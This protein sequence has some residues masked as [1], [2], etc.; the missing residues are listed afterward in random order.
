MDGVSCAVRTTAAAVSARAR[1]AV[2]EFRGMGNGRA[3]RISRRCLLDAALRHYLH[4]VRRVW[5]K[6]PG[7]TTFVDAM[8][9]RGCGPGMAAGLHPNG[10]A[11]PRWLAPCNEGQRLHISS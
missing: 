2:G 6:I 10:P 5:K 9:N 1:A 3:A 4:P 7:A 11:C 8:N